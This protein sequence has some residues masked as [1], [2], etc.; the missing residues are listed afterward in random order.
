MK[1]VRGIIRIPLVRSR[2][3]TCATS[4]AELKR[5]MLF[6]SIKTPRITTA[7]TGRC[8]S[9]C[10]L[11][12]QMSSS[13]CLHCY[14][15]VSIA[16]YRSVL[17]KMCLHYPYKASFLKEMSSLKAFIIR[18][19][20]PRNLTWIRAAGVVLFCE[21]PGCCGHQ[22]PSASCSPGSC[23]PTPSAC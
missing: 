1:K 3:Q 21:S 8:V 22:P 13:V 14:D 23:H 20:T 7:A 6:L 19:Q 15:H 11:V 16:H 12:A 9:V 17:K 10:M 2:P 5:A 4:A 18:F